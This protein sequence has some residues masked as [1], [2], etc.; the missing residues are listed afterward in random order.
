MQNAP[1]LD[2]LGASGLLVELMRRWLG[3]SLVASTD[4]VCF[5]CVGI[6]KRVCVLGGGLV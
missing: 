4:C 6:E 3:W 2:G 1:Q 5:E